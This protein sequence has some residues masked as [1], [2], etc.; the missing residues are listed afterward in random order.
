MI[1]IVNYGMGNIGSI[2]NMLKKIGFKSY[3][4][5]EPQEISESTHIII[6]GVGAYDNAI[7]KLNDENWTGALKLAA[8]QG[9]A[10]LGICLG[11]Q[12]LGSSSEE[13]QLPGLNLIPGSV[14]KFSSIS[15]FKVPHMGWNQVFEHDNIL[16]RDLE[17]NKF[18]FVHSYYFVPELESHS[19]GKTNYGISFTSVIR[20]GHIFGVQFHPEKSHIYGSILLRNFCEFRL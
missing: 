5:S 3:V 8:A 12:L 19:T 1:S 11:M 14:R 4:A 6:P 15:S 16:F 13:G 17:V 7:K 9:K 10:L 20:K 2:V 18:Y